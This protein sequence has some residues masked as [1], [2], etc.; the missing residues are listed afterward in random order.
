VIERLVMGRH[1]C[2][3]GEQFP[4]LDPLQSDLGGKA[5]AR[6]TC[7]NQYDNKKW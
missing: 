7:R 3:D 1:A 5:R 4:G 2:Q 6:Q